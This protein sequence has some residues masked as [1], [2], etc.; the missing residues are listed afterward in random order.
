MSPITENGKN[1]LPRQYY[2]GNNCNS[3]GGYYY[4]CYSP[5]YSWGRWVVLIAIIF[6]FV[7][8]FLGV[9]CLSA[10]R[11]RSRGLT[12]YQGTGWLAG[13][14]PPGH[15]QPTYVSEPG[16]YQAQ[17]AQNGAAPPY[18]ATPTAG[19]YGNNQGATGHIGQQQTGIELQ[20]PPNAY[21]QPTR[22]ADQVYNAPQ[23]VDQAP[24]TK[25]GIIR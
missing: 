6:F 12:P 16:G 19:Y 23:V 20:S 22:G 2:N 5:F 9:T 13:K 11:R 1:L 4:D 14:T 17:Y 25:D 21:T 10:R 7:V 18:G 8:L 3:Y 24:P 15:A